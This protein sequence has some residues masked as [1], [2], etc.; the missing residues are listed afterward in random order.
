M[1]T[2]AHLRSFLFLAGSALLAAPSAS[3]A[4]YYWDNAAGAGFGTAGGTWTVTTVSQWNTD[5]TGVAAAGASITTANTN[6][7]TDA[8]NFG[9][10]A[11]G[12][13][14]GTIDVDTVGA[15]DMTFASG[16][17][18]IVL[19][20]STINLA[21]A[22]TTT[23]NNATD[24]ISSILTGAGTSFTKA[25]TG[26]LILTGANAYTGTTI[27]NRGTLQVGD[28]T[29]GSL[30][31]TT[32]TALTFTDTGT[33]NVNEAV[34]VNQ[35]MG[36]LTLTAGQATV[37]STRAG[38]GTNSL[39][40]SN[41]TARSAGATANFVQ[42]GGTNGTDNSIILTQYNSSSTVAGAFIDKGVFFNGSAY[43][44]AHSANGYL[45][46]M[47][48]TG[49]TPDA[50]TATTV[51]ASKHVQL[52]ATPAAQ[53]TISLF[54]L[55]LSGGA[56]NYT[57]NASQTL[58]VPGILK[59]GEGT[60]SVISG[61]TAVTAGGSTELV[62]RTDTSSDLLRI[63]TPITG[64]LSRLT[65]S[66][67]G[68]LTLSAANTYTGTTTI[69]AGTL[70][71]GTGGTTGA[72]S[73]S[74]A[75][76]INGG[77]NL[78][79]NRSDAVVQGTNFANNITGT[80]SITMAGSNT[81]SLGP[82][83]H[84]GGFNLTSGTINGIAAGTYGGFGSGTLSISNGT[85][86]SFPTGS[87]TVTFTN[88]I[89]WNG[90]TFN[91][92]RVSSGT[93]LVNFDGASTLGAN[94]TINVTAATYDFTYVFNGAVGDGGSG[95]G[96]SF[97]GGNNSSGGYTLKGTNTFTGNITTAG[98]NKTL[99]IGSSG[100]LNSGNYAG[101]IN[102]AGPFQYSSS[103]N[104]ALSGA[105]TA[106]SLTKNT[107]SASTLILSGGASN[108]I[109]GLTSVSAGTLEL[110][111]SGA[112]NAIVSGGLTINTGGTVQYNASAGSN[113]IGDASVVTVAGGTFNMNGIA[114]TLGRLVFNSGTV[115]T[116]AGIVTLAGNS[117]AAL[118]MQNTTIG[119]NLALSN[120]TTTGVG[121][122]FDAT[123]NGTAT[124]SGKINLNSTATASVTRTFTIGDGA[125]TSD[126]DITGEIFNTTSTS[127][128]KAGLGTLTLSGNNTYTRGTNIDAGTLNL[129]SAQ[130]GTGGPLGGSG[131]VASVGTITFG[132]GT[133]QYSASN[134]TDYSSRFGGGINQ[135]RIDTNGQDVTFASQI[136]GTA[137]ASTFT[138][139]GAGKLTLNSALS[140][141]TGVTTIAG[142]TLNANTLA[143]GGADSSIGKATNVAA[144]LVIAGGT[145]R[146]DAANIASTDRLFTIGGTTGDTATLD[147]SATLAANSMSFTN[148]GAV[149]FGNTNAHTLTLTGG[150][151]GDNTFAPTI[152]DNTGATSLVK[153]GLGK[154]ELTSASTY[155]GATT[156]TGGKLSVGTTGTINNTS[157]V[158]IGAGEFSYNNSATALTQGITFSGSTGTLSGTGTVTPATVITTG[159]R[160]TAGTSITLTNPAPT[161]GT[162]TFGTSIDYQEGSIFEWSLTANAEV[163]E[164]TRGT[165]YD[166]VNTASLLNTGAEAIFR[167]VLNGT[168]NFDESFWNAN[169]SWTDI[170]K[171]GGTALD[172]ETIFGTGANV[173][174][175]NSTGLIANGN[176]TGRSFTISGSTLNWAAVPEP[177]SALVGLL[178][179][180]GLLR[181]RN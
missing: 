51:T 96:L 13:G 137:N 114:D 17:G 31:G 80:G 64:T 69:N 19:S 87:P 147:S 63:E 110:N 53:N 92:S 61:G 10:G 88:N 146:H 16:S 24:T 115:T 164:G 138:K 124:V 136:I 33:F 120:I 127:L 152:G 4:I 121:V 65:K 165:N 142:G 111:K 105:I 99:T 60:V 160:Q 7:T 54:S 90:G 43:A 9:N 30:N 48:Y 135:F 180:A 77:G 143:A 37:Q 132:G 134:N 119:S 125:A 117:P 12:L 149:A 93:P 168:E 35:G 163:S 21:T 23:V 89:L 73:T 130:T 172:I 58:T 46:G 39:T 70:Q 173:E 156:V 150:N 15:G 159:N 52:T 129:G 170:F 108:V 25:G 178:V 171:N 66:G 122:T 167:V 161:L 42:S 57:Q 40:F 49:G 169:R 22:Q 98:S 140:R 112:F 158:S 162:Q 104:Q 101:A 41:V 95:F 84:T 5:A 27:I 28:G 103:S 79:I 67:A 94:Q 126:M 100:S 109:S 139:L 177:T 148:T 71:I 106:T 36:L 47:I 128:T 32:G 75:V 113:Q 174:Y 83:S 44:V 14:A 179:G 91:T 181:R 133:L 154:W 50:N 34:G 145:L 26:T 118:S 74:S 2:S 38:S 59:S 107:S 56:V 157:G 123:N 97:T 55:N 1:K 153:D 82:N 3:A 6:G 81:L 175:Y 68:T 155:T 116:S 20:G 141:Y 166:A 176:T 29:A 76:V 102:S 8:L 11:T 144:N 131:T 85:T 45:R 151:T 78:T 86:M 72:I 62:I 18:A